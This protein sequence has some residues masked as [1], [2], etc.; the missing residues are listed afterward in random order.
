MA[1]LVL[2]AIGIVGPPAG[3]QKTAD[4]KATAPKTAPRVSVE[5]RA[6][7]ASDA[8]IRFFG[9]ITSL[10]IIGWDRD[11][12]VITGSM[13]KGWVFD[14]GVGSAPVGRARGAKFF[15]DSRTEGSVDGAALEVRVPNRARVWAKSGSADIEVSGV[16]GGL[17]LNIVGGSV[18]VS[19]TPRELSIE[20]MDGNVRVLAGASWLRVKTATGDIDVRGGSE[21]AG[22]SSVSGRIALSGGRYERGKFETV[23][24][25]ITYAG[26]IGYKG[27]IDLTTHSGRVELLLPPKPSV[28]VDAASVTGTIENA[29]TSSRPIAGREG[30]G[31]ELGFS[32]GTGDMRIVVRSFKGN[33]ELKPR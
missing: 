6:A 25:D 27:T 9:A 30:R 31:M 29:V 16:T 12:L 2:A 33:V 8:S 11:S 5:R 23:T 26:D 20:S 22:L 13:P 32:S 10:K 15:V 21:D 24:G 14:G 1:T 3:A 4:P 28:E 17:D 19:S 7:V 18:V